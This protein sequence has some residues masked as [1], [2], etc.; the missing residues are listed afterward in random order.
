MPSN[1]GYRR[2]D[3]PIS[4]TLE[5]LGD[6]WSLLIVRDLMFKDRRCFKDF[7]EAEERIA[8]NILADRLARLEAAGLVSKRR[9]PTDGRR[10]VYRL[11]RKG[12]DLAPLLIEMI[13]W[14]ASYED[15]G[16]PEEVTASMRS[17]KKRFLSGI[18]AAWQAQTR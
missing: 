9:D 18:Y 1:K 4:I 16:A 13:L 15:T 10:F 11:T 2:S 14:A 8:S 5:L 12:I 6:P 17:N 3:C 7:L